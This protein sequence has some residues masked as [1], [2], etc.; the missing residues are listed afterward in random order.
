VRGR[1]LKPGGVRFLRGVLGGFRGS[2]PPVLAFWDVCF[3]PLSL[4]LVFVFV[5]GFRCWP[6]RGLVIF[7][8]SAARSLRG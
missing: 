7:P 2:P 6:L 8:T 1:T 5:F 3:L 4:L